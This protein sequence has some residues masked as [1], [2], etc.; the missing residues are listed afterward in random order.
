MDEAGHDCR[1]KRFLAWGLAAAAILFSPLA[2]S[3]QSDL[4][5]AP[6]APPAAG[7]IVVYRHASLI[8]GRGGPLRPDM[9][10]VTNGPTIQQIVEDA[11]LPAGLLRTAEV[12]DLRGQYLLPG[13]IDAHQHLTTPPNRPRAEAL[14]RRDLYSGITAVRDMADDLRAIGDLA[15]ASLV[16][17]IAGPD[18]YYA[19]LMAGPSFFEDRRTLAASQGAEPGKVP[20]MQAIT[21]ETD[22][23]MAITLARG[24][25]ASGIKIYANLPPNLVAKITREAHRQGMPVWAHG[26]VFPTPPAQV[27]AAGPDVISHVC[28]LAY[29]V[30]EK[31][32]QSYQARFPVDFSKFANG[33]NPVMAGLFREM[34]RRG[35]ILDAT[36]RVYAWLESPGGSHPGQ[37]PHCTSELALRL[38]NQAYREGVTIAAGTDGTTARDDP[39]PALHEELVLLAERAEMPPAQVI[40]SATLVGATTMGKQASMGTVEPGKLANLVVV[41]KSPLEDIQNLRSVVMTVKRGRVFRRSAFRPISKQEMPE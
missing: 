17:E 7:K 29:Q 13:L 39:Y 16:G 26:M 19:A 8:D 27:I 15:R 12:I 36:N 30:S 2:S 37:K 40:R 18:I 31:R 10:V 4:P 35:T 34:K 33:D 23:P 24:T 22:M 28:Y 38:T 5:A 3:A 20:W 6:L 41:A 1:M 9:A 25:Y 32:P 21:D 14:M 11:R